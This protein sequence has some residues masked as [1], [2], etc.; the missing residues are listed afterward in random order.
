MYTFPSA[1]ILIY[2]PFCR[3]YFKEMVYHFIKLYILRP[4]C[5]LSLLQGFLYISLLQG[6][7]NPHP[8]KLAQFF[9]IP[10]LPLQESCVL[11]L[12]L[13]R[14]LRLLLLLDFSPLSSSCWLSSSWGF[15]VGSSLYLLLISGLCSCIAFVISSFTIYIT[16]SAMPKVFSSSIASCKA[17]IAIL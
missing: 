10:W 12:L 6:S 15:S 5:I 17:L 2:F 7:L 9:F 14:V 3:D 16:L 13:L 4:I 1:G 11:L 8:L